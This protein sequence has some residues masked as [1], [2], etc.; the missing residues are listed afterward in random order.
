[1]LRHQ[2][3]KTIWLSPW[4]RQLAAIS[5]QL[6]SPASVYIF[7]HVKTEDDPMVR[8]A[9]AKNHNLPLLP[10]LLVIAIPSGKLEFT[11]R[12]L[13]WEFTMSQTSQE[14][15]GAECLSE[16]TGFVDPSRFV[17]LSLSL[18]LFLMLHRN[19]LRPSPSGREGR[20]GCCCLESILFSSLLGTGWTM[21][22]GMRRKGSP[23]RQG[24]SMYFIPDTIN[25]C[26]LH[27][28][29]CPDNYV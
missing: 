12:R 16:E 27:H 7:L 28:V 4:N 11:R 5:N 17:S 2:V 15:C 10:W 25:Q 1:L 24:L 9:G 22:D 13:C 18:S 23:T 29:G 6:D 14:P 8:E 3:P 20:V 26:L 19:T 21:N